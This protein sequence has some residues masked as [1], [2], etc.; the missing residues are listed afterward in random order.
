MSTDLELLEPAEELRYL[1]EVL[2]IGDP[3]RLVGHVVDNFM[4][5]Q[6]RSAMLLSLITLCLTISGFSGHRIAAAGFEPALLL[7]LGLVLAVGAA[8]LLLQGP[9]RLRWATRM[10]APGGL[11]DTLIE[12]IRQRNLRTR[13]YHQ[14]TAVLVAGL[15]SYTASLVLFI[16]R[17]GLG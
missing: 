17:E 3:E 12:L 11:E 16:F 15:C 7:G 8:S 10:A 2:L 6:T 4:V 14:A 1:R 5:L 13:R 9:L